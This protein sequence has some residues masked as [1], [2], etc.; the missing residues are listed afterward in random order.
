MSKTLTIKSSTKR[1]DVAVVV[2]EILIYESSLQ[3]A[4]TIEKAFHIFASPN[5]TEGE[6]YLAVMKQAK[7]FMD[8]HYPDS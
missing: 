3:P 4:N 8:Q 5:M 1:G 6:V 7:E 2:V